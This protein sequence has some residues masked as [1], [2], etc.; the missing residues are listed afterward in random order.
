MRLTACSSYSGMK[1]TGL[2]SC[3]SG[4]SPQKDP[5][6]AAESHESPVIRNSP[7]WPADSSAEAKTVAEL[8]ASC[9]SRRQHGKGMEN[10]LCLQRSPKPHFP[11]VQ[12]SGLASHRPLS[13]SLHPLLPFGLPKPGVPWGAAPRRVCAAGAQRCVPVSQSHQPGVPPA[14]PQQE[15][16]AP[17]QRARKNWPCHFKYI[18]Q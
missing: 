5:E 10:D 18:R 3:L 9:C 11:W 13:V 4:K 15:L 14:A 8:W 2:Q 7:N 12:E 6:K 1:R 16:L 17:L